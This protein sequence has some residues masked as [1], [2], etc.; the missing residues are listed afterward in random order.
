MDCKL[1]RNSTESLAMKSDA[2]RDIRLVRRAHRSER[3]FDRA[4]GGDSATR[5]ISLSAPYR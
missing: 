3:V 2:T 1:S 4:E 5:R